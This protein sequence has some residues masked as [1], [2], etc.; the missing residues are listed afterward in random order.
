VADQQ[1]RLCS[2]LKIKGGEASTPVMQ[3]IKDKFQFIRF[4]SFLRKKPVLSA[5][6]LDLS[7]ISIS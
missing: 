1:N 5:A 7:S 6:M 3:E 4:P 2:Q